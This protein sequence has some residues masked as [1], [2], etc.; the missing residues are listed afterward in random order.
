MYAIRS[1]YV[2]NVIAQYKPEVVGVATTCLS[3]TIGDDIG[4]ALRNYKAKNA[5]DPEI[6]EFVYASTPSYQGSHM[7]GFHETVAAITKTFA[8][9]VELNDKVNIFP[10]F[11]S[12]EDLRMLKD[13]LE[14]FGIDYIMVPDY[15]ETLDN[16]V[17]DTYHRIPRNNFV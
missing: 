14:D 12:T 13:I 2:Q 17:W 15:S 3:E 6:P 11:L 4:Q 9:K 8:T 5:D 16:P 7:D 1:Y 10:G